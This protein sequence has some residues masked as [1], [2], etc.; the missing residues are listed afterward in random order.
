[1]EQAV[2]K[3]PANKAPRDDNILN[4]IPHIVLSIILLKLIKPF[5]ACMTLGYTPTHF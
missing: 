1:M 3:V 4:G 5:D 2:R